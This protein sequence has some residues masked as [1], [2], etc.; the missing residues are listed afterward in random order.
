MDDSRFD[1]LALQL[2][3]MRDTFEKIDAKSAAPASEFYFVAVFRSGAERDSF[4]RD[5]GLPDDRYQNGER[6]R[7]LIKGET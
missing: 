2:D 5:N 6:L 4:L 7:G 3:K 1:E